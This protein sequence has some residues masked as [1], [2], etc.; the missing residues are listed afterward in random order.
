MRTK[1]V[2]GSFKRINR[3]NTAK[4]LALGVALVAPGTL[5]VAQQHG[6]QTGAANAAPAANVAP[7]ADAPP[8]VELFLSKD[9]LK[10]IDKGAKNNYTRCSEGHKLG[11]ADIARACVDFGHSYQTSGSDAS[12]PLLAFRRSCSLG[13]AAGCASVGDVVEASGDT[14]RARDLWSTGPC[15]N[16][17]GCQHKLFNSYASANPPDVAM[18]VQYGVPLCDQGHDDKVCDQL[19][20]INAPV[21]FAAI[22][23]NHRQ[24]HIADL[25]SR[26]GKNAI[27][28]PLLQAQVSL[29]QYNV[30]NSSG[31]SHILALGELK[32]AEK[33]LS[34]AQ[35]Q[36]DAM[37]SE[38]NQLLGTTSAPQ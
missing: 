6:H 3:W 29:N 24:Q 25:Q 4:A 5:A 9:Q 21:D 19:K 10:S 12:V 36:G 17:A 20:A 7:A 13:S 33:E 16:D 35:K 30:N 32:L 11:P 22:A 1:F 8:P 15:A 27:S 26:I 23:E 31:L 38:L 18:A 34:D 2:L 14:A 37:Q 28:I